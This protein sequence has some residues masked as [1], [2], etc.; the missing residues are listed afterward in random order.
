MQRAVAKAGCQIFSWTRLVGVFRDKGSDRSIQIGGRILC[1]ML[2]GA[3]LSGCW[4]PAALSEPE[5]LYPVSQ[6]L[7][8]V[9]IA[10]EDRD[11][12]PRY[13]SSGDRTGFRNEIISARMYAIDVN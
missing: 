2:A 13:L 11:L 4:R 12:W 3:A 6:E 8:P 9:K 7:E 10:Y 1:L 5:R